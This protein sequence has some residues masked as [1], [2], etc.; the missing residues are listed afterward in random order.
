MSL[1]RA[2]PRAEPQTRDG[3]LPAIPMGDAWARWVASHGS[4]ATGGQGALQAVAVWGACDLIASLVSELPV[5]VYRGSG[6]DR[7]VAI[8]AGRGCPALPCLTRDFSD[9]C[10]WLS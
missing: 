7:R 5:H 2:R 4:D 10:V 9:E 3:I 6:S 8:L 1:W